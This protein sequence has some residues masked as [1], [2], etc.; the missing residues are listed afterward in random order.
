M[1]YTL[2]CI[3]VRNPPRPRF[4]EYKI[5]K[6]ILSL[7]SSLKVYPHHRINPSTKQIKMPSPQI[8][9]REQGLVQS[10]DSRP[11]LRRFLLPSS[12]YKMMPPSDRLLP[13]NGHDSCPRKRDKESTPVE[14]PGNP[15][16][17]PVLALDQI[18]TF[19]IEHSAAVRYT[20]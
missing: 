7:F 2:S 20:E 17:R 18:S 1:K 8:A 16:Q 11:P 3:L 13:V 15:P 19:L 10:L 9:A 5:Q 14:P 12:Y 6:L 4:Y